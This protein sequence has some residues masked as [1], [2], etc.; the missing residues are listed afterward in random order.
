MK[1]LRRNDEL[2]IVSPVRTSYG[3]YNKFQNW[4]KVENLDI[5]YLDKI[6]FREIQSN[7]AMGS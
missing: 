4:R 7:P 2:T 5:S 3:G 6:T 1:C